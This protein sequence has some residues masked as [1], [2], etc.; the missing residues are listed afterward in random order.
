MIAFVVT[1]NRKRL[2]VAGIDAEGVLSAIV[3]YVNV[4]DP[5]AKRRTTLDA[6]VGGLN[7]ATKE[8]LEWVRTDLK[9]GD[10]IEILVK[11]EKADA[12][13]RTRPGRSTREMLKDNLTRIKARR[14]ALLRE[15]KDVD[16]NE[17]ATRKQLGNTKKR[18]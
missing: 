10:R 5:G 2:C 12:A 15:L 7:S 1:K 8:H 16:R 3:S 11:S 13:V 6:R 4:T 18:V 9:P 14:K 17:A